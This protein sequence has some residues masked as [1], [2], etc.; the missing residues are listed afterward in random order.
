MI[1]DYFNSWKKAFKFIG[2]SNRREYWLFQF[3][4][5]F[6][7]F[8]LF[9][10]NSIN[11]LL[12]SYQLN[13]DNYSLISIFASYLISIVIFLNLIIILASVFVNLSLTIRRIS[14]VG[15]KWQWIFIAL[16][17]Y[18]G[19]L[20]TLIFLTRTSVEYIDGKQYFLKH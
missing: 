3:I 15:M 5:F 1:I 6:W 16:F 14:D 2:K 8:N 7:I 9:I 4:S 20:F 18:I 13:E 10:F 17:P 19:L 11:D 12:I